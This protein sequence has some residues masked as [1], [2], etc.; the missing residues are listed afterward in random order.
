M[1]TLL[2]NMHYYDPE[3][4]ATLSFVNYKCFGIFMS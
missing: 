1:N 4:T 3:T 2:S